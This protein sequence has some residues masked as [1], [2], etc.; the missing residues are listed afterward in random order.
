MNKTLYFKGEIKTETTIVDPSLPRPLRKQFMATGALVREA[1]K[2]AYLNMAVSDSTDDTISMNEAYLI[3]SGKAPVLRHKR[4]EVG[5]HH[6]LAK[7][8]VAL[9]LFGSHA[10]G[11]DG[12]LKVGFI[13][14]PDENGNSQHSMQI[15]NATTED[16]ALMSEIM[17]EWSK[18]CYLGEKTEMGFGA[19]EV[20]WNVYMG[21]DLLG[22]ITLR[23]GAAS[24][25]LEK[26]TDRL[27]S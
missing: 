22:N 25:E 8:N 19:V 7:H 18:C 3:L 2:Q 5:R 1:L 9:S 17:N 23:Q 6:L 16:C 26:I 10:H 20:F 27:L 11:I 14:Q 13:S 24:S 12:R 15:I 4:T 21:D